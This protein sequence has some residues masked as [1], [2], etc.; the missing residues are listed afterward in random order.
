MSNTLKINISSESDTQAFASS[1]AQYFNEG[2]LYL[3]GDLGAGKTTFTR[4]FLTSLGHDGAVKSP[5]YTLVEPYQIRGKSVFHFD[6]YRLNDPYELE[7]MGIRDYLETAHALF[8]FEWPSKGK[9][10]IPE[11]DLMLEI[12]RTDDETAREITIYSENE[13]LIQHLQEQVYARKQ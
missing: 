4:Y 3:I 11:A 1:L 7:L 5:T 8:I 2:V 6:L 13:A 12:L 10:E 9:D